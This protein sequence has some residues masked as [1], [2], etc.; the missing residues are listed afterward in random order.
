MSE[1][2]ETALPSGVGYGVVIGVGAFFTILMCGLTV[3]QVCRE[4]SR[5][6]TAGGLHLA[7]QIHQLQHQNQ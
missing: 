5:S 1:Q 4:Q 6:N 3:I 2:V 7:E